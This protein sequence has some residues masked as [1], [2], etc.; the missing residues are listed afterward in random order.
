MKV[1][2][3]YILEDAEERLAS[4][5]PTV[6]D[7][8]FEAVLVQPLQGELF[9]DR[10]QEPL[11]GLAAVVHGPGSGLFEDLEPVPVRAAPVVFH[12]RC[13]RTEQIGCGDGDFHE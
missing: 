10:A 4:Q 8:F 1:L 13:S 2:A 12:R 3:H 6:C 11:S 9:P 5:A 7:L